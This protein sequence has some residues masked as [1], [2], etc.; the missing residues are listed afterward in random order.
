MDTMGFIF[1][2]F[3]FSLGTLGFIFGI[4]ATNNAK[5]AIDKINRLE[6]RLSDAGVL[7]SEHV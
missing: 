1:G 6:Q 2:M 4:T 7:K 3:G 5:S